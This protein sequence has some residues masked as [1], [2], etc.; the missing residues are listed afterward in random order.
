MKEMDK[1]TK[2]EMALAFDSADALSLLQ[3]QFKDVTHLKTRHDNKCM[4]YNFNNQ[5]V[6]VHDCHSGT[7]QQWFLDSERFKNQTQ[8]QLFGHARQWQRVYAQLPRWY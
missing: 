7:N 6:Y 8:R 3:I 5:N 4:D 2:E 1:R